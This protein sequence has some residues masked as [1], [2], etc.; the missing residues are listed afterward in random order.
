M[1]TNNFGAQQTTLS[2]VGLGNMGS[3]MVRRL[4][5]AGFETFIYSRR[6]EQ[7]SALE[8]EGAMPAASLAE[9]GANLRTDSFLRDATRLTLR[10]VR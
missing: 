5:S 7:M 1:R 6:A 8:K 9:F 4:L 10:G 3:R 2:F